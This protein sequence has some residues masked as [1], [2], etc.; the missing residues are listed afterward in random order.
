MKVWGHGGSERGSETGIG[1]EE[2]RQVEREDKR[3]VKR[4]GERDKWTWREIGIQGQSKA[5]RRL[6][7]KRN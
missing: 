5:D 4:I 3:W 1:W 2:L 6:E 7:E